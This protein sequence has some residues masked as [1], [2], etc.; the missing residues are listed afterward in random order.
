[1]KLT[2]L[3]LLLVTLVALLGCTQ[4]LQDTSQQPT[5]KVTDVEGL[6]DDLGE[7]E[8]IDEDLDTSDLDDL[9]KDLDVDF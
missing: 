5:G 9:D 1:M 7:L 3:A 2:I 8:G 6:G 4:Q